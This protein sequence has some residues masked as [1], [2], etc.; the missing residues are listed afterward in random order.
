MI[1]GTART[2]SRTGTAWLRGNHPMLIV[3]LVML[4][5]GVVAASQHESQQQGDAAQ[6][7]LLH[8]GVRLHQ[9]GPAVI[10]AWNELAH[11]IAV[12]EDQFL[13]FKGQR[14]LAI[15][16]IAMHDALNT[17]VPWYERYA[18]DGPWSIAHPVAAVAQAGYDVLVAQ[19]PDQQARVQ[20]ELTMWLNHVPAGTWRDRGVELGRAT[21]AAILSRR[22][23]DGWDFPGSYEFRSGPGEYRTTPPW[24][25]FVAQ[26]GFR[27]A[28]PFVLSHPSRFRPPP[29]P[30]LRSTKYARALK[31]VQEFGALNSPSRSE[32]Q[33]AYAVWWME[34]AEGSVN[35]LAR[36]LVTSRRLH[37]WEAARVFAHIGMALF[38]TY[39]A[40]WDS[41]YEYNH[42]RPYT[43]IRAADTDDNPRTVPDP[44]WEPLRTTPPFPDYVSAHATACAASFGV[45]ERLIGRHVPFTMTTLTAPP[46]M[47]TR[48]FASFGSAAHECAD[49]RVRLGYHFR[50]ATDAGL[51]LGD[52]IARHVVV[53]ALRP[54]ITQ[55]GN[56]R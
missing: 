43:A 22:A 23:N 38:D 53:H 48:S 28:T 44:T 20:T 34:F 11:D 51:E 27:L 47:P 14:A 33:T 8:E 37:L 46:D 15:M 3:G 35:R 6:A 49:S 26:P 2:R 45:L 36:Q 10:A 54:S 55:G 32:D 12:A 1:D 17:I 18:Y 52:R 21:A 16:H 41:K 40:V 5:G 4:L 56:Q 19:Y 50:Y 24:N 30:A 42:W 7:A 39:V 9:L 29:P 25:G 31:E 13:T